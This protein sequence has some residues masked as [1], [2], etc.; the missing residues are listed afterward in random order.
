MPEPHL[1][2]LPL[3][4]L[5]LPDENATDRLGAALAARVTVGTVV[6]LN[7][8][9]GAGK[10]RLVRAIALA[11]GVEAAEIGSPTFTLV[12]EYRTGIADPADSSAP[13]TPPPLLFH[14]DAYRLSDEVDYLNLGPD[15][16]LETGAMLIEWANRV[17][18]VLPTDRLT[19]TLTAT[20]ETS[21]RVQFAVGGPRSTALLDEL[22]KEEAIRGFA[23]A[24]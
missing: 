18:D 5:H 9:L 16:F 24:R 23:H 7:G 17:S 22:M 2:D 20:G 13:F 1:P 8:E 10:T 4:E 6:G 11:C 21:R 3:A 15:E 19:L 14:L 12:R